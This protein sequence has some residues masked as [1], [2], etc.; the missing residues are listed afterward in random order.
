MMVK[1]IIFF[2]VLILT[3]YNTIGISLEM[4][5]I[6]NRDDAIKYY[7]NNFKSISFENNG[8]EVIFDFSVS[9]KLMDRDLEF[10][11]FFPDT[12]VIHLGGNISD[13]SLVYFKE[14]INLEVLTFDDTKITGEGVKYLTKLTKLE[15]FIANNTPF[16]DAG[17]KYLSEIKLEKHIEVQFH[18]TKITDEGLK[19]LSSIK[20]NGELYLA[21]TKITDEGLKYLANQKDLYLIDVRE[22][23]VTKA[24]V[25]WLEKQLPNTGIEYG[26]Y[27][28]QKD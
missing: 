2:L 3:T 18:N 23:K 16:T 11:S 8:K 1:R 28:P 4:K 19:Y 27:V 14:L 10:L 26:N 24:G 22:T 25:Q 5:N 9:D 6:K 20:L 12:Y 17:L 15:R 21:K 13:G 7:K